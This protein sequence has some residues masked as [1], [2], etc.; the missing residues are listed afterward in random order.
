MTNAIFLYIFR[1]LYQKDILILIVV[2]V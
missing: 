1:I 2:V